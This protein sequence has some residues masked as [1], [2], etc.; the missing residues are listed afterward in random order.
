MFDKQFFDIRLRGDKEIILNVQG[1][2]I[3]LPTQQAEQI[4]AEYYNID[5]TP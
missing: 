1:K 2:E 3:E 5:K 4:I